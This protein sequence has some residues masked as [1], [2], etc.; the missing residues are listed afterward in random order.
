[1]SSPDKHV[2]CDLPRTGGTRQITFAFQ[3]SDNKAKA[4]DVT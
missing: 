3:F 1:M 4:N 2:T